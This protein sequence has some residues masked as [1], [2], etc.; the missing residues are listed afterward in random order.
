MQVL[1]LSA[2]AP[3]FLTYLIAALKNINADFTKVN[4]QLTHSVKAVWNVAL[5]IVN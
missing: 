2:M 1:D 3:T 4:A 5:K